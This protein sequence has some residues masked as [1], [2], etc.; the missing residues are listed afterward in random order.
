MDVRQILVVKVYRKKDPQEIRDRQ[1]GRVSGVYYPV[2]LDDGD[3]TIDMTVPEDVYNEI[4]EDNIYAF[5]TRFDDR[6]R[7]DGQSV[8]PKIEGLM[9]ELPNNWRGDFLSKFN[10]LVSPS[11]Y[12]PAKLAANTEKT[13]ANTEKSAANK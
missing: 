4:Q 10:E 9:F 1:T 13:T 3:N 2:I 11:V 7:R 12:T 5:V 6:F 8:K